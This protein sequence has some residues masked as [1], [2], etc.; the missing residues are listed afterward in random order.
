MSFLAKFCTLALM[1]ISMSCTA[2]NNSSSSASTTPTDSLEKTVALASP[3]PIQTKTTIEPME[4]KPEIKT[5]EPQ[6][7]TIKQEVTKVQK[8]PEKVQKAE[9][10]LEKVS[11]DD[12]AKPTTIEEEIPGFSH[13]IW[14]ELLRKYVTASGKVNYKG[15]KAERAKLDT[16]IDLL[17]QNGIQNGWSRNEKMA[18]W[19]NAYNAYTVKLIIDNYPVSS[20][21]KL[22]GGSPWKVK[23]ATLG[24][25]KYTLDQIE[26]EILRPRFKDARIHFAVNCA[27]KSCPPLLN[28]AWTADKLN[29]YFEQQARGFINND[30]YN[31]IS[32]NEVKVSKIFDWYKAD[33]G[34][35]IEY[36]NKYSKVTIQPD[37]KIS[38]LEYNWALNN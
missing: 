17:S 26:N 9:P 33:F 22:H 14:D 10:T 28:R 31:Q 1:L 18:Y 16:Y 23:L 32:A 8:A 35:L 21:T 3:K 20:I 12:Q 5:T 15:I 7:K 36:L 30:Q 19:I 25:K 6:P 37:A 29:Q 34:N 2:D 24:G 4:S 13:T 38:Y 11:T 27:A